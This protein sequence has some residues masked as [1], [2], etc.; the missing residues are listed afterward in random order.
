M[1]AAYDPKQPP[2]PPDVF[3][4]ALLEAIA[5]ELGHATVAFVFGIEDST[6]VIPGAFTANDGKNYGNH[7]FVTRF[8]AFEN[9]AII[10]LIPAD[11]E[12]LALVAVAG[13]V[14]ERIV[15]QEELLPVIKD[16][17]NRNTFRDL[18]QFRLLLSGDETTATPEHFCNR[19]A[20]LVRPHC[21]AIASA[22]RQVET[23]AIVFGQRSRWG[24]RGPLEPFV[25][26]WETARSLLIR[27][28][29]TLDR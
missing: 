23:D 3:D 18:K 16:F 28:G 8:P 9:V 1:T 13:V 12:S 19:A 20:A 2:R 22:A 17:L 26:R 27:E 14:T 29:A 7:S 11:R 21:A 6:I 24:P 15:A 10:D 4:V 25:V 5:H